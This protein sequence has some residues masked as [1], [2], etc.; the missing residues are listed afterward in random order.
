MLLSWRQGALLGG[1]VVLLS[2]PASLGMALR[3]LKIVERSL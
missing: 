2:V 3:A 1:E